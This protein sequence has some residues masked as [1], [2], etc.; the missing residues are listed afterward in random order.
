MKTQ[1]ATK[2]RLGWQ[3]LRRLW[4]ESPLGRMC[5]FEM[6]QE[7]TSSSFPTLHQENAARTLAS[8]HPQELFHQDPPSFLHG[9][10][11]SGPQN[12]RNTTSYCF[13][14]LLC[15]SFPIA[16][17]S[18]TQGFETGL[19]LVLIGSASHLQGLCWTLSWLF[20]FV[21]NTQSLQTDLTPFRTQPH[22]ITSFA[23]TYV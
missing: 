5:P 16:T 9:L 17:W 1:P 13:D 11:L 15:G 14:Y 21:N 22:L 4:R 20:C 8:T 18:K 12:Y 6:G 2:A 10:G 19:R 3:D 23:N 7:I